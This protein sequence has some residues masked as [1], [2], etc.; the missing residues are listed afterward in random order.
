MAMSF[1]SVI[2]ANQAAGAFQRVVFSDFGAPPAPPVAIVP[3]PVAKAEMAPEAENEAFEVAPGVRLPTAAEVE[4]LQNQAEKEGYDAGYEDGSARGRF[5]AAELHQ[6]L[7][8]F[9]ETLSSLDRSIAEEILALSLEVARLV[10]RE[11]IRIKPDMILTVVREALQQTPQQHAQLH[12][13][14]DDSA[15]VRQYLG[16]QLGH[17]GHRIVDDSSVERGGCRIESSGLQVDASVSTRWRR[18]VE[19]LSRN[20]TWDQEDS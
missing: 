4:A 2:R 20:H 9:D 19:N 6:L 17:A 1:D 15:L 14:P 11:S 12:L 13:H 5:E 7:T 16:E 3:E 10:V 8:T 18:V